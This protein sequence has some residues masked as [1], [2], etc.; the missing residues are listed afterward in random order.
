[1][2]AMRID[3]NSIT[4]SATSINC[5]SL[6][7]EISDTVSRLNTICNFAKNIKGGIDIEVITKMQSDLTYIECLSEEVIQDE[8]CSNECKLILILKIEK[9]SKKIRKSL[10]TL[11][12]KDIKRIKLN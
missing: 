7:D 9:I 11:K 6:V 10:K 8:A 2:N 12:Q 5:K 1:M 4:H 3:W